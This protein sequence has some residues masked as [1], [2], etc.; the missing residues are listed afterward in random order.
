M[1]SMSRAH[2]RRR[3]PRF[4]AVALAGVAGSLAASSPAWA[5]PAAPENLTVVPAGPTQSRTATLT[6]T[7][8]AAD[9]GESILSYEGGLGADPQGAIASPLQLTSIGDGQHTFSVRAVQSDGQRSAYASIPIVVDNGLPT[10]S[11]QF[12]SAPNAAGWRRGPLTITPICNDLLSPIVACTPAFP[13]TTDSATATATGAAT[14][15]AGNQAS[16]S[17]Q[18]MFDATPPAANEPA[19]PGPDRPAGQPSQPGPAALVAAEPTFSWTPG[20]DATSGVDRYALQFRDTDGDN[21][22]HTIANRDD[23]GGIGDYSAKRDPAVWGSALPERHQLQWRIQTFDNAGNSRT[24]TER[25]LTID[26]TIPPPPVITGGPST[27]IRFTSP[28]FSWAG[29]AGNSFAWDLTIPGR[30]TPVRGPFNGPETEATFQSL[31]D[32]AY[33]FRVSQITPFGQ[34][35]AQATRAFVVD[36]TPPVAPAITV[37]PPFPASGI[38]TF[39]WT[40]EPGAY[41]RWQI[42][43]AGG[44]VVVGPSDTPLNSVQI[45]NLA[46]GA[47]SFQVLQIDAAGN[48]SATT[49][50]PFTVSTPLA[51]GQ[52]PSTNPR[53]Q[54]EFL[55]P[56]QNAARLRPKAGKT[57][58]TRRPVLSW[59]KGP[60]GTRLYN[61][62]IFKVVKKRRGAAPSVKKVYSG[63]PKKRQLRAP[64]SKMQPGTCYV[65]RVWPY[66]GTRF[67]PKPLG[68]SNFCVAKASVLKKK[69]AQAAARKAARRA[70]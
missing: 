44:A 53:V 42:V 39:G 64:K 11:F 26:S 61:V 27:P 15:A 30:E 2:P 47:Y 38:I 14:D 13:W 17:Q 22:W 3:L 23:V 5:V 43:G 6:W 19:P 51:P 28:T 57:L 67:T 18:F 31:A 46:D 16:G 60:R 62:Q 35:G 34:P 9:P 1:G 40:V 24:S 4:A 65:W 55:L 41:S 50:E 32:G 36:T 12:S 49:S 29:L 66:T 54:P 58:P 63:F 25:F 52:T 20:F 7:P 37:R 69:A 70:R 33:T 56:S 8:G 59:R 48:A 45:A 10:V 68:I 21:E